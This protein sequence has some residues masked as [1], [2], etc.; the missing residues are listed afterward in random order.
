MNLAK[1]NSS[2][3]MYPKIK[4]MST[5]KKN[6]NSTVQNLNSTINQE[7]QLD[8]DV[9]PVT[10]TNILIHM[11]NPGI[12]KIKY[13]CTLIVFFL[14]LIIIYFFLKIEY[15]LSYINDIKNIFKDFGQL[16]YRYT[17][18]YYYYNS[19]RILLISKKNGNEDV[20]E[21]YSLILDN[22]YKN[23]QEILNTRIKSFKETHELYSMLKIPWNNTSI[24]QKICGSNEKCLFVL[25]TQQESKLVTDGLLI[26]LDAI[27]QKILNIFNDYLTAKNSTNQEII[28]QNVIDYEFQL[29]ESTL[30]FVINIVQELVYKGFYNDENNIKKV[31]QSKVNLFNLVAIFYCIMVGIVVMFGIL[32]NLSF[33][34]KLI[35]KGT[36]RINNAFCYIKQKN[37]G[38][39][40]KR[41]GSNITS[42]SINI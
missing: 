25:E 20:F 21:N 8:E 3:K 42:T 27:F 33:N 18:A 9:E 19:L 12:R 14:C 23:N 41:T 37:L 13:F 38:I 17:L 11:K 34:S 39:K 6:Q 28:I 5:I 15:S 36:I 22:I 26:A 1:K 16:T 35:G 31:F 10:A 2:T 40:I 32:R 24:R 30:S 29:M 7:E 4:R